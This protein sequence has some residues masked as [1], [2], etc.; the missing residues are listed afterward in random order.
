MDRYQ[1]DSIEQYMEGG[2][3]TSIYPNKAFVMSHLI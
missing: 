2:E 3:V 1:V